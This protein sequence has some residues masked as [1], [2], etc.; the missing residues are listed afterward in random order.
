MAVVDQLGLQVHGAADDQVG[1]GLL[2]RRLRGAGGDFGIQGLGR[3]LQVL[4][5]HAGIELAEVL[6]HAPEHLHA[7][8]G[9]QH[10]HVPAVGGAQ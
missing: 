4:Q 6:Q 7:V 8:G 1:A 2:A 9:V 10:Q 5:A 3:Q